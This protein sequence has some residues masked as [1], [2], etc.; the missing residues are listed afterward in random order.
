MYVLCGSLGIDAIL[1]S[2]KTIVL[3]DIWFKNS[4]KKNIIK[5]V[6]Y[7]YDENKKL[8]GENHN[9]NENLESKIENIKILYLKK[10]I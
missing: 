10:M 9:I 4:T 7:F 2:K 5:F 1:R 8:L 6:Q 3:G